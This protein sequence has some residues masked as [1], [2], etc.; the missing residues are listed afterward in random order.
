[1]GDAERRRLE[2]EGFGPGWT[3]P[4]A[5]DWDGGRSPPAAPPAIRWLRSLPP[6]WPVPVGLAGLAL[7]VVLYLASPPLGILAGALLLGL[8]SPPRW[9]SWFGSRS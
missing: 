7:P 1:V 8:F 5:D 6:G 4:P 3:G 9:R 2:R